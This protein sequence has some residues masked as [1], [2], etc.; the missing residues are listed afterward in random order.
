LNIFN[1]ISEISS[2]NPVATIGIF[3]GVHKGHIE[4]L[5]RIRQLA[6][7]ERVKS[8]VITLWPHPRFVL[9]PGNTDLKLLTSLE[10]KIKLID[11]QGIDNLFIL[12]FTKEFSNI[13]FE[14]FISDYLIGKLGVRHLVVGYNH[15]FGKDRK[16][17]FENLQKVAAIYQMKVEK[18]D[19]VIIEQRRI[20]SSGIRHMLEEGRI[21]AANEGL[22]YHYFINGIVVKGNRMGRELGFPTANIQ[23]TEPVKLLPRN[24]VYAVR[25]RIDNRNLKGMLNIG[26]RP[27]IHSSKNER[28]TE[29][30]LFR[31]NG[32]IYN[33]SVQVSF[34]EWLRCEKKFDS[35]HELKE[36]LLID[37]EEVL[38]LFRTFPGKNKFK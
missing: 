20:S 35:I 10:E 32:N 27:T 5:K 21:M 33:K 28:V 7:S 4:I 14:S 25:A 24:G 8:L 26:V 11:E 19:P 22:G 31:F 17:T 18:V 36:Q 13:P 1:N 30:H 34:L 15:H 23:L 16:G 2:A 29:V 6:R 9:N 12:P 38:K 3:D 37:K